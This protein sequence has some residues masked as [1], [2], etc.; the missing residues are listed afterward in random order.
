MSEIRSGAWLCSWPTRVDVVTSPALALRG[1]HG[2]RFEPAG[3]APLVFPHASPPSH[4]AQAVS[5]HPAA[6]LCL[7]TGGLPA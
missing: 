3:P 6:A 4:L 5:G 1:H 2:L 7:T